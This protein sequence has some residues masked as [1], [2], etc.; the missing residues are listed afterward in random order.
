MHAKHAPPELPHAASA[1]PATQRLL[2]QQPLLHDCVSQTHVS[3]TQRW[4]VAH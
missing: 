4:P 1:E 2:A 3:F